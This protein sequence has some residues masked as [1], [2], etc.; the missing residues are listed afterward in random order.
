VFRFGEVDSKNLNLLSFDLNLVIFI[1]CFS[2]K[3]GIRLR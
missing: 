1:L 3:F 2:Y